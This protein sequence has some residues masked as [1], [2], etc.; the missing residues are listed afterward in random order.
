M[1]TTYYLDLVSGNDG[2]SGLAWNLP[3]LTFSAVNT[4]ASAGDEI[5]IA[6][7]TAA[8]SVAGA[9]FG[10]TVNSVTVTTSADVRASLAAGDY[11]GCT[12]AAGN[13]AA[14]SYYCIA[15]ITASAIT[16]LNVY[17][18]TTKSEASVKKLSFVTAPCTATKALTISGGWTLAASP[19]QDGET[20]LKGSGGISTVFT[21]VANC[22]LSYVNVAGMSGSYGVVGALTASVS[23]ITG[24]ASVR[25]AAGT[26]NSFNSVTCVG[27]CT[28]VAGGATF[29]ACVYAAGSVCTSIGGAT[30]GFSGTHNSGSTATAFG[31][32][33]GMSSTIAGTAVC[34]ADFC[35][36]GFTGCT[37]SSSATISATNCTTYG[38]DGSSMALGTTC[39]VTSSPLATGIR[40]STILGT[41]TVTGSSTGFSGCACI[42]ICT[43]NACLYGFNSCAYQK[44][45]LLQQ[46]C[47]RHS[48]AY[49][50]RRG[51][52]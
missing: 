11:I 44:K 52:V 30:T 39:I 8:S 22:I 43:A 36:T 37:I 49:N 21:I 32:N 18:G 23:Y 7:T 35:G 17:A 31:C 34:N 4:A 2:N 13:G 10:W 14:E 40:G 15:A 38:F 46:L 12:T 42:G 24:T 47:D 1:P 9:T 33:V 20:W 5:R 41:A 25:S 26:T 19:T 45:L 51:R 16:L 3:K 27:P 29:N 6:K 50:T 48:H 28:G